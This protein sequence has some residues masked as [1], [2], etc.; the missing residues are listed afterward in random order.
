[1]LPGIINSSSRHFQPAM[2]QFLVSILHHISQLIQPVLVPICFVAAW[3]LV[4][5]VG[6]SLW[7]A[8]RDSVRVAQR[9]H[10]IPCASCQFYTNTH[11]LKCPVHPSEAGTEDAVNCMDFEQRSYASL[12][13]ADRI[14]H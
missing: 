3:G 10:Q 2:I 12:P 11:F 6:L 13:N 14:Y 9:M 4:S 5:L 1:M 7:T 8:A